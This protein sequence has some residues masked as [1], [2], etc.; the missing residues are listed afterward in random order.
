MS[1][2]CQCGPCKNTVQICP[3]VRGGVSDNIEFVNVD[4]DLD[5]LKDPE[6]P[7]YC[8]LSA[9]RRILEDLED[10]VADMEERMDNAGI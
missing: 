4:D 5:A 1:A 6:D 9:M 8:A 7:L 2:P 10:R 3:A